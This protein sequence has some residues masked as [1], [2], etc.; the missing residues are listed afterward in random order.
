LEPGGKV[1][2]RLLFP[3]TTELAPLALRFTASVS[4][5]TTT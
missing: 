1:R 4:S 3:E 5:Q 2:E